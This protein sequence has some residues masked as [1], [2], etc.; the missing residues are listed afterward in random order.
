MRKVVVFVSSS[1]AGLVREAIGEAG[2]GRLGNYSETVCTA[3]GAP[4]GARAIDEERI[5][6]ACDDATYRSILT[7][8]DGV[9]PVFAPTVDSWSLETMER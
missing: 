2:R 6:F 7:A 8:I 9:S 4:H 1:Q 3:Q 5:E